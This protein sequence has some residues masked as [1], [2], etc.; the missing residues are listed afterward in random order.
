MSHPL[1]SPLVRYGIGIG[2][3]MILV[4]VGTFFL[5]PPVRYFVYAMAVLDAVVTPWIL[6]RAMEQEAR[7]ATA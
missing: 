1:E 2:G 3:A 5:E 4:V 6:E 7:E